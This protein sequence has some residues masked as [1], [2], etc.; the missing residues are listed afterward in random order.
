[1]EACGGVRLVTPGAKEYIE[2]GV[3]TGDGGKIGRSSGNEPGRDGKEIGADGK[4]E[5]GI[6]GE[7]VGAGGIHG[8]YLPPRTLDEVVH[9]GIGPYGITGV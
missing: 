1:L 6:T 8:V 9:D 7:N 3:K 4:E 5:V 2:T